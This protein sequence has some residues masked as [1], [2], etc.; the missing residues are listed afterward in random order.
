V[1]TDHVLKEW[2]GPVQ[3]SLLMRSMLMCRIWKV[4]SIALECDVMQFV[5]NINEK[6]FHLNCFTYLILNVIHKSVL[7]KLKWTIP[8]EKLIIKRFATQLF[9][10]V[11]QLSLI[12]AV[13]TRLCSCWVVARLLS[14]QRWPV[15]LHASG[16]NPVRTRQRAYVTPPK[17]PHWNE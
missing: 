13:A 1:E 3:I 11:D 16:Y 12:I 15:K 4:P 2:L 8:R 5:T 17:E 6:S 7:D 9:R 10:S 14:G